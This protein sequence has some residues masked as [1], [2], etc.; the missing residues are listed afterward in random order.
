M[1]T[2]GPVKIYRCGNC[3]ALFARR[4]IASGNTLRARYRSDGKMDAPMLPLSPPLV[5]CPA[6]RNVLPSSTLEPIDQYRAYLGFV[7]RDE[8]APQLMLSEKYKDAPWLDVPSANEC[9]EFVRGADLGDQE[10]RLRLFTVQ[11]VNDERL[12]A[13]SPVVWFK[14]LERIKA[15]RAQGD[16]KTGRRQF[17]RLASACRAGELPVIELADFL[18]FGWSIAPLSTDQVDNAEQLLKL[19][20]HSGSEESKLLRVELLRELGRFD[21]AMLL[22]DDDFDDGGR[23]E[24][25]LLACESRCAEPFTYANGYDHEGYEYDWHL[26]RYRPEDEPEISGDE[27]P[28][29]FHIGNRDWWVKVLGM[30]QHNWALIDRNDDG[31]VAV[32]FF[33]DGGGTK[34]PTGY[35]WRQ[36]RGRCAVVDSLPFKSMSQAREGLERYGFFQLKKTPGPWVGEEPRGIIYDARGSA[37]RIYS[38]N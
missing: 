25:L 18:K 11:R 15:L 22:L 34:S 32:Y 4:T 8:H 23:A 20:E 31:S 29:V 7:P 16:K 33:H 30:L 17:Q 28:P 26:R 6:C 19:L 2:P 9:L 24:Q 14:K 12:L 21:E 5:A 3:S 35:S 27:D 37:Q 13:L 36:L 38:D 10:V 1:T